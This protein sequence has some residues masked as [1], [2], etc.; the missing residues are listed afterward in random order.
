MVEATIDTKPDGNTGG[1]LGIDGASSADNGLAGGGKEPPRISG[2]EV[3]SPLEFSNAPS[4]NSPRK[5][6]RP[7]G[8]KNGPRLA[9]K[10]PQSN[11]IA[12][13]ES[14]LLSV[15]L[16]GAKILE[17]P[18]L[19]LDD[20]EAKRLS[21]SLKKVAEFYPV[22]IS[23][24]RMAI[25]ELCMAAGSIYGPRVVTLMKTAKKKTPPPVRQVP[26]SQPQGPARPVAATGT[27]G[28]VQ[29]APRVPS[30]MWSQDGQEAPSE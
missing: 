24:K 15:H 12:N 28:P 25:A 22:G 20:E 14:L 3:H 23:P 7:A 17:I 11:L 16:M 29:V 19:E 1:S 30:E 2:F 5:R 13:F 21:D 26:Q 6:G 8:S 27:T 18:E 9:E 10:T 4:G